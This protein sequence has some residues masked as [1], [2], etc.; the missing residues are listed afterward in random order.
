MAWIPKKLTREQMEERR[1]LGGR[2]LK[3][4]RVSKAEIARQLGVSRMTVLR[5][6]QQM[7]SGGLRR[8]RRRTASGRPPRL[9]RPQRQRVWRI[10]KRGALA[11]GFPTDR[12]T[13]ARIQKVIERELGVHYNLNYLSQ[14]L[15]SWDWSVQQPVARARERDEELIQ[16]WLEHDWPRIK[17]GAALARTHSVF[18]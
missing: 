2:W 15:Q 12:W 10:L 4:G 3:A 5:W 16:A 18:R 7:K 17:K 6:A 11:A 9:T 14:L 1:R 13:L 8:L